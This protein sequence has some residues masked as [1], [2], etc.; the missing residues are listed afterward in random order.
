M[1]RSTNTTSGRPDSKIENRAY[2]GGL[3]GLRAKTPYAIKPNLTDLLKEQEQLLIGVDDAEDCP[4]ETYLVKNTSTGSGSTI[5]FADDGYKSDRAQHLVNLPFMLFLQD[6]SSII[7]NIISVTND[8][9]ITT[10]TYDGDA[11]TR[12]NSYI[13]LPIKNYA[14]V[15]QGT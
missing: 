2:Y 9:T 11:F 7:R 10:I 8:G 14:L 4:V 3:G 6:N 5:T 12:D 13:M 1:A 15:T